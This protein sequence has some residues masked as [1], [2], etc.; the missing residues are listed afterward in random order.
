M[1]TYKKYDEGYKKLFS[2]KE[3]LIWFLQNV[4]NEERFKRLEKSDVE[5]IATE[6]I[7]KKWQKKSSD[8]VYKIKYKDSFFCLTIE[9][10]SRE[11]K[12]I[13]HRLYEYMHLIQL[14]NKVNGEIPV[15]VPIV[16]YNGISHWKPN[17]QYSEIILFA[18]DFPEYAQN[19]KIIFLDIKS[20]PEEKLIS[21]SNV[22]AIAMYIDQVSNNSERVLNRILNLRG[23]IHLN[24]EQR[25]EL[26]DW[27]YEVILRSYGVSEEEAEEMFKKSGLEVDEMFSSTAEKI[28]QGIE[29]EKKKLLKRQ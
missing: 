1:K 13:L 25:E 4:L 29:R 11:D 3:N 10:Q 2:N 27:L 19:F 20:I 18:E 5:I 15:V 22:L 26:A 14:K 23:K 16:L 21:A 8:I 24:W 12:K 28:K 9:F 17:E 7:N 6:S